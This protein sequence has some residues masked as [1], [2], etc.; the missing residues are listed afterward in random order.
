[1]SYPSLVQLITDGWIVHMRGVIELDDAPLATEKIEEIK[2]HTDGAA[3]HIVFL[4]QGVGGKGIYFPIT[5]EAELKLAHEEVEKSSQIIGYDLAII[6][7]ARNLY[8]EVKVDEYANNLIELNNWKIE[9]QNPTEFIVRNVVEGASKEPG[10]KFISELQKYLISLSIKNKTGVIITNVSWGARYKAQPFGLT[11]SEI[12]HNP[13]KITFDDIN[14]I[15]LLKEN[16]NEKLMSDLVEFYG[17]I[18]PRTKLITG[19]SI[20]ETLFDSDAEHIL[21]ISEIDDVLLK[22]NEISSIASDDNKLTKLANVLK[23]PNIM[24]SQGRNERLAIKLAKVMNIEYSLA[25]KKV[26]E[27]AKFR[28]KAAHSI[29]EDKPEYTALS[30]YIEEVLLAYI[31]S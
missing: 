1:M 17:Q 16:G 14:R 19:F 29:T 5:N 25:Y 4:N 26:K 9:I 15:E 28:G 24:S 30:N 6:C 13:Q 10:Y 18:S 23:N 31:Y 21:N 7:R 3:T 8:G 2:K 12:F 22:V 27:L 20:L 11:L